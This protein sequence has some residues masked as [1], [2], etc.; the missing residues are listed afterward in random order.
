MTWMPFT[1]Q[2]AVKLRAMSV[3]DAGFTMMGDECIF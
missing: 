2:A 1:P 3:I